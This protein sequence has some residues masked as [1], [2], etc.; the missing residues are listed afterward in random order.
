[1]FRPKGG[2]AVGVTKRGKGS[3]LMLVTEGQGLPIGGMV[4]GAQ[5]AE[6]RLA[7]APLRAVRVPPAHS[8]PS[9]GGSDAFRQSWRRRG[10]RP[11]IPRRRHQHR[12][13]RKP[14]LSPYRSRWMVERTFSWLGHFR[15]LGVRYERSVDVYW[16]FVVLAFILIGL[17]RIL[18]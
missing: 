12:R 16:A 11:C 3:K 15:R 6:M 8:A 4:A 5:P 7:E 17:E 13:G 14:D 18:K 2:E 10:I 9:P 1:L